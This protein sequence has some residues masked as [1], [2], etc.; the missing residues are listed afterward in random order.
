MQNQYFGQLVLGLE[1]KSIEEEL[2][3]VVR[4]VGVVCVAAV[5]WEQRMLLPRALNLTARE[6]NI[7]VCPKSPISINNLSDVSPFLRKPYF[8]VYFHTPSQTNN[9]EVR[10]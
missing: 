8:N 7:F 5:R 10:A 2:Q 4:S 9:I 1:L 6:R 3:S